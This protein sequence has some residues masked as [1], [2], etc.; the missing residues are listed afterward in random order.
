VRER[1]TQFGAWV[2]GW[3]AGLRRRSFFPLSLG[4]LVRVDLLLTPQSKIKIDGPLNR[5][6]TRQA[7]SERTKCR[8][9]H[10]QQTSRR[11]LTV[12]VVGIVILG[13]HVFVFWD[14]SFEALK[15]FAGRHCRASG[16]RHC[17]FTGER[18]CLTVE[19]GR[20]A[21]TATATLSGQCP[22]FSRSLTANQMSGKVTVAPF[23]KNLFPGTVATVVNPCHQTEMHVCAKTPISS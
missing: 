23:C 4:F 3:L 1:R 22:R 10:T 18:H 14:A 11:R 15:L 20:E 12:R 19:A 6:T 9:A 16:W 21:L 17:R 7:R 8:S 13:C 2:C 5:Q